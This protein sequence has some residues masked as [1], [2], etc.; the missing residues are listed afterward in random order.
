MD[1]GCSPV[2]KLKIVKI[3]PG[4]CEIYACEN[5]PLC[6]IHGVLIFYVCLCNFMVDE[7]ECYREKYTYICEHK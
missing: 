4:I 7:F 6:G 5:F 3:F 1:I 2:A